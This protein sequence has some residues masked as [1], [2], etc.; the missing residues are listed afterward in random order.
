[1]VVASGCPFGQIGKEVIAAFKSLKIIEAVE[2]LGKSTSVYSGVDMNEVRANAR[3]GVSN[4]F[5]IRNSSFKTSV[6]SIISCTFLVQY[7]WRVGSKQ[8]KEGFMFL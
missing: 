3:R 8:T 1:M 7:L 5:H 6:I 4:I 2:E